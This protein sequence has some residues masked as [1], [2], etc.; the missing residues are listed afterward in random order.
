MKPG[1]TSAKFTTD[2]DAV[3]VS[4]ARKSAA[5]AP[6]HSRS[7]RNSHDR[8]WE[9]K[10]EYSNERF[11]KGRCATRPSELAAAAMSPDRWRHEEARAE[12]PGNGTNDAGARAANQTTRREKNEVE[13]LLATRDTTRGG[14]VLVL[15][16]AGL[17]GAYV[18]VFVNPFGFGIAKSSSFT[19]T[20]FRD[21]K[22]GE[23][24]EDVVRK[25]GA[26]I[27]A[28]EPLTVSM[29]KL[30]R[31]VTRGTVGRSAFTVEVIRVG[32]RSAT[33]SYPCSRSR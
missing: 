20:H 1:E 19:W 16:A 26:P 29:M 10:G 8:G 11:A 18:L 32:R 25:L 21:V 17:I 30:L 13:R 2:A 7:P 15:F 14:I 23:P 22:E 3:L 28:P 33:A 27:R 31:H 12:S 9:E 4:P 6:A 5:R 24:I